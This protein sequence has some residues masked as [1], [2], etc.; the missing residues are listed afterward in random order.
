MIKI[1]H[2]RKQVIASFIFVFVIL[3]GLSTNVSAIG[4]NNPIASDELVSLSGVV[5]AI[6]D[7]SFEF[8]VDDVKYIVHV[9]QYINLDD[10]NL[11]I[12]QIVEVT[13]FLRIT[14]CYN[15]I[16]PTIINGIV[17]EDL[18][19]LDGSGPNEEAVNYQY[20]LRFKAISHPLYR[21]I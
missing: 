12:N 19:L 15:N 16:Y 20:K 17:L 5:I 11:E 8:E 6:Y 2:S 4:K 18:K 10:L 21:Y 7:Q 3:F 9:P 14:S 1:H 13:G